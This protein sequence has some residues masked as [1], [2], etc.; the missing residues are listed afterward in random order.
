MH[1]R[2]FAKDIRNS[3]DIHNTFDVQKKLTA[4][5]QI[6]STTTQ[7]NT[8]FSLPR[9]NCQL[10]CHEIVLTKHSPPKFQI[11]LSKKALPKFQP[12]SQKLQNFGRTLF[13]KLSS[14]K[15]CLNKLCQQFSFH[16]PP[17]FFPSH[18]HTCARITCLLNRLLVATKWPHQPI[19]S[20][21]F[22]QRMRGARTVQWQVSTHTRAHTHAH[23]HTHARTHARA[24][25]HAR[26]HAHTHTTLVRF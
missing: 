3:V 10:F 5:L 17:Q 8:I 21:S 19:C 13:P 18:P 2:C 9:K 23:A 20:K 16:P 4:D 6:F 15:K 11:F 22:L 26:T 7:K 25:A 14:G 1:R 24:H 12:T